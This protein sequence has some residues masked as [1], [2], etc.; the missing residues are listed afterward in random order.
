[1]DLWR[2]WHT[3]LFPY[4]SAELFP[5]EKSVKDHM[6]G[7]ATKRGAFQLGT[8]A[9]HLYALR[10]LSKTYPGLLILG[11]ISNQKENEAKAQPWIKEWNRFVFNKHSRINRWKGCRF[12]QYNQAF[13]VAALVAT[14]DSCSAFSWLCPL[15]E[16][17]LSFELALG[18]WNQS[19]VIRR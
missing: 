19:N 16:T 5:L 9:F 2:H 13:H 1:M 17:S 8:W 14:F 10:K 4:A 7:G 15:K 18:F 3:N 11:F 12:L 6:L